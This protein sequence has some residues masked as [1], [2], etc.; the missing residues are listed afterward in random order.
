M[1]DQERSNAPSVE[2]CDAAYRR[3]SYMIDAPEAPIIVRINQPSDDVDT[4][5]DQFGETE[6]AFITAYNPYSEVL[7]PEENEKRHEGLLF[8]IQTRGLITFPSYGVDDDGTW[9]SEH[10]LFVIGIT[11]EDA[12]VLGRRLEQNAIVVGVV[13]GSPEL[14]WCIAE[15]NR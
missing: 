4:L 7:T 3:T 11:R 8:D 9:P 5:V 2:D 6:W 1:D 14:V 12:I 13:G 10:G 15:A